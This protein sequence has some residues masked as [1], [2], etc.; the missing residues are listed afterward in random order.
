MGERRREDLQKN[1]RELS[2]QSNVWKH[3][4]TVFFRLRHKGG[5]TKGRLI[6]CKSIQ[7]MRDKNKCEHPLESSRINRLE[8]LPV[9]LLNSGLFC[10]LPV[11]PTPEVNWLIPLR[12]HYI[13]NYIYTYIYCQVLASPSCGLRRNGWKPVASLPVRLYIS[14]D[15]YLHLYHISSIF[16]YHIFH[17]SRWS[18]QG[19]ACATHM[20]IE[21]YAIHC[22]GTLSYQTEPLLTMSAMHRQKIALLVLP[23]SATLSDFQWRTHDKPTLHY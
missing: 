8:S 22:W 1:T 10:Q 19:S 5:R 6:L 3:S 12:L 20:K 14:S 9:S 18:C 11:M 16:Q 7:A 17:R 15:L 21:T 23:G 13:Y 2:C 4:W